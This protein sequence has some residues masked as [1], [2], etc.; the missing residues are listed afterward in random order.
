LE[1][2]L[3]FIG[4]WMFFRYHHIMNRGIEILIMWFVVAFCIS[5]LFFASLLN[6]LTVIS[7]PFAA[8]FY[9]RHS[10]RVSPV[11][12]FGLVA[13]V[14]SILPV[15]GDSRGMVWNHMLRWECIIWGV[16]VLMTLVCV[17]TFTLR[18]FLDREVEPH[19]PEKQSNETDGK[20]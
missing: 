16:P 8:W 17:G 1:A 9:A 20:I 7:F 4:G 3:A 12:C 6:L 18:R 15:L 13:G 2:D 14:L 11:I 5:S 10:A 19:M